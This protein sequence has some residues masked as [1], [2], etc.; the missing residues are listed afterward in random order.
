MPCS[1]NFSVT[2]QTE[3]LSTETSD[4]LKQI[5]FLK[6]FISIFHLKAL[7]VCLWNSSEY[8]FQKPCAFVCPRCLHPLS[9]H[10][11]LSKA[12]E[13]Q[14]S[15][16]FFHCLILAYWKKYP[17]TAGLTESISQSPADPFQLLT[18]HLLDHNLVMLTTWSLSRARL[19]KA[20][21]A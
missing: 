10:C 15:S 13:W 11:I 17:F 1:A 3:I 21:L 8:I 20:S 18:C 9:S 12:N 16:L 6:L 7:S 4:F 2:L 19:F 5:I 14:S